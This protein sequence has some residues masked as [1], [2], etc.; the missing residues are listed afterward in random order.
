M[1]SPF[2]VDSKQYFR[3]AGKTMTRIR[4]KKA[5]SI[6]RRIRTLRKHRSLRFKSCDIVAGACFAA[7]AA[8]AAEPAHAQ[9]K[10][11]SRT[12]RIVT[13]APGSNHDWGARLTAHE[14]TPRVGQRVIVEN[15]GSISIEYVAKEAPADGY[16]LLF[17]GAVVWLQPLLTRV[18][19][20]P[21][22]DFAPV[23]LAI[24]AP[25]VLVVHPSLPVKSVKEL[26]ALAQAR[27]GQLNYGAGGGGST[28]HSRRSSSGTWRRSTSC[29]S[30]TRVPGPRISDCSRVKCSSCSPASVRSCRT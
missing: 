21:F 5:V 3:Q 20:D 13:A 1:S 28:P 29:A 9:D 12:I 19:W 30:I 10:F 27:P 16:T 8:A 7:L 26:I 22:A 14:L 15:R 23:S 18:N 6:D 4:D 25:N 24:G 2:S 11:P 17:Y